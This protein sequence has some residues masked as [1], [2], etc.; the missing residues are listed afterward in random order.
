MCG[1]GDLTVLLLSCF[2]T[3][4]FGSDPVGFSSLCGNSQRV[5]G[6]DGAVPSLS[7]RPR[8]FSPSWGAAPEGRAGQCWAVSAVDCA[9]T[10][11]GC[12]IVTLSIC[13]CIPHPEA[14]ARPFPHLSP[15]TSPSCLPEWQHLHAHPQKAAAPCLSPSIQGCIQMFLQHLPP[16]GDRDAER[17]LHHPHPGEMLCTTL[18][19]QAHLWLA[20]SPRDLHPPEPAVPDALPLKSAVHCNP[21]FYSRLGAA[22]GPCQERLQPAQNSSFHG[23]H[24]GKEQCSR[25][26]DC[27]NFV[28]LPLGKQGAAGPARASPSPSLRPLLKIV[29]GMSFE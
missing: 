8:E 13:G 7:R 15:C 16:P 5:T 28:F 12:F 19:L 4:W 18:P 27:G 29:L 26:W 22:A 24:P 11:F 1:L 6:S 23:G 25:S 2:L 3:C 10:G 20:G 14:A 9:G 17:G 21:A